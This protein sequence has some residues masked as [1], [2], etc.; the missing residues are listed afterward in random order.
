MPLAGLKP[1]IKGKEQIPS[2]QYAG[3][4]ILIISD[5][6]TLP[7]NLECVLSR[8]NIKKRILKWE[9]LRKGDITTDEADLIILFLQDLQGREDIL[10]KLIKVSEDRR[11]PILIVMEKAGSQLP[12]ELI[13][14][15]DIG[16]LH[17][18]LRT[19]SEEILYGRLLSIIEYTPYLAK[20]TE[21]AGNVERWAFSLNARFEE[22]HQE[23]RLAWRV[24]KDFLPKSLPQTK[25]IRFSS[26]YRPASWVSGDIY[27]V[28]RLDEEHIGVYI[29]DVVGHGVAAGLITL[30]VKRALITKEIFDNSY[31]IIEP[32]EA[33]EHLNKEL[34]DLDLPEHHFITAFYG[35]INH[36]T[37]SFRFARA[38]HPFP[39]YVKNDGRIL[40][41]SSEGPLLGV[42]E[43]LKLQTSQIKLG[44]GEKI[45]LYSDGLEQIL[46]YGKIEKEEEEEQIRTDIL[47]KELLRIKDLPAER[48]TENLNALLDCQES[49]LHPGD[50]VTV[51]VL[52]TL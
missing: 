11:S 39:F 43:N 35:I 10:I 3:P 20:L 8:L 37:L 12:A 47:E 52:E 14:N 45:I 33:L 40:R 9:D 31:R 21:Y 18:C 2:A 46:S 50:D 1:K 32:A 7:S 41:I 23:L 22:L 17:T 44:C 34:I 16:P 42:F 4:N 15:P 19:E 29:A 27:D 6:K 24:Q 5:D 30:F 26:I 28:F 49:S 48:F 13:S 51:I 38:G 25:S 36:K